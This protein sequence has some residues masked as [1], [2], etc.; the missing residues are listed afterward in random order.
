VRGFAFLFKAK[1]PRCVKR[2]TEKEGTKNGYSDAVVGWVPGGGK[3]RA[4]KEKER[5]RNA[6]Y[7]QGSPK[8]N[9]KPQAMARLV[10]TQHEGCPLDAIFDQ[11]FK[12]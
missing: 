5:E 9:D 1:S 3:Q 11:F 6:D 7:S 2:E 10:D 12:R 8:A 4:N